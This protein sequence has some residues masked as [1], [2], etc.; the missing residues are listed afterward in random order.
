MIK[1]NLYDREFLYGFEFRFKDDQMLN[2]F[3][4]LNSRFEVVEN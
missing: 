2:E 1:V 4:E 3:L